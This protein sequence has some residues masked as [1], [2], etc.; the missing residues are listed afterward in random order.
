MTTRSPE[1]L[2]ASDPDLAAL[3]ALYARHAPDLVGPLGGNGGEL[4]VAARAHLALAEHRA[5][6]EPVVRVETAA[7]GGPVVEIITD[8]MPF[9]VAALLAA[10]ARAG[11]EVRRVLHPI[12]VVRRAPDGKLADVLTR[13]DP[14]APP[15]DTLAESWTRL[16]L[17]PF[18]VAPRDLEAKL[19]G[20][21]R[22]VREIVA[23]AEPMRARARELADT[24]AAQPTSAGGIPQTDIASLLRWFADGHLTFLGYRHHVTGPD[25]TLRPDGASGLGMLRDDTRGADIGS[26]PDEPGGRRE[27]LVITRANAPSPLKPVHA[28]LPRRGDV[29]RRGPPHW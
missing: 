11:G 13:A 12:V 22:E 17:A 9:L 7:D 3:T 20:V 21:L 15:P 18:A 27:S 24:L 23:D 29:R 14:D 1:S 8:D 28:V 2:P 26:V 25:G 16:E 10:I 19:T 6:G 4:D 5:S